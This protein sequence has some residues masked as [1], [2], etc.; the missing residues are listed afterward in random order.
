MLIREIPEDNTIYAWCGEY[1]I[2][3]ILTEW[4]SENSL[5]LNLLCALYDAD[6]L[7]PIFP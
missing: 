2:E 3:W 7:F 5:N 4:H 6:I 1:W